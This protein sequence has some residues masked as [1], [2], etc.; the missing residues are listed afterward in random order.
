[1]M[2]VAID[3]RIDR[4]NLFQRGHAGLHEEAHEAQ[5]DAVLGHEVVLDLFRRS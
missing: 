1:M 4:R 5:L 3:L 2:S